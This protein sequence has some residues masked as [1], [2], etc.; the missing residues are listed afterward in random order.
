[1]FAIFEG[2]MSREPNKV[3]TVR[4]M[5]NQLSPRD[6]PPQLRGALHLLSYNTRH[7]KMS[8]SRARKQEH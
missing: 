4:A 3:N 1:M 7:A 6:Y 2:S 5:F 8:L